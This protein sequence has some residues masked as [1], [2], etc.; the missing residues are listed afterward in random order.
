M[1]KCN[2]IKNMNFVHAR[3][4]LLMHGVKKV[5]TKNDVFPEVNSLIDKNIS[6]SFFPE[7]LYTVGTYD[8]EQQD[9]DAIGIINQY[10]DVQQPISIT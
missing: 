10:N 2:L 1:S 3:T 6:N 5:I 9:K 8:C 7:L 4:P